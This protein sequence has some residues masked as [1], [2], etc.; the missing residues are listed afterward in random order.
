M[1]R[2]RVDVTISKQ[3]WETDISVTA[4]G[5]M[6][7]VCWPISVHA[8]QRAGAVLPGRAFEKTCLA[9]STNRP[10]VEV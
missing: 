5:P 10:S 3:D 7:V 9:L 2:S 1:D 6:I 8:A 4:G